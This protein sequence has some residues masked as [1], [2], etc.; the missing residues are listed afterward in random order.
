MPKNNL[1]DIIYYNVTISPYV[2]ITLDDIIT[3]SENQD[4]N[5]RRLSCECEP[6]V[7]VESNDRIV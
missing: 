2:T 3:F 6:S 7:K 4:N 5:D 1:F